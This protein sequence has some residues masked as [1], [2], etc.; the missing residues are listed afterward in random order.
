LKAKKKIIIVS[1]TAWSLVNFRAGLI[2][3][4]VDV[5]YEVVAIAPSDEYVPLLNNLGCRYHP[6]AMDN[7]G[8]KV[9]KDLLLLYRFFRILRHEQPVVFL[10]YTV[11]PNV[12]GSLA[13]HLLDIPVVNNISGLGSVFISND[14]LTHFVKGL[15]KLALYRSVKIFF[16]NEDDRQLFINNGLVRE[17]L[18]DRLPGSGV[19]IE[20]FKDQ[21]LRLSHQ[22][23]RGFQFLLIARML[24]DKGVG[25]YVA[26]ARIIKRSFPKVEFCLLGFLGVENPS[27]ISRIQMDE[28][29]SE[30]VVNYL[31]ISEDVREQIT[32][33]DCIVLPSYYRE[34]TPRTLLEAA[35]MSR[36]IITTDSV[37][38]RD[39]VDDGVNGYLCRPRDT[40][41][42]AK[43]MKEMISLSQEERQD[44]GM[45]GREKVKREFDE[46]IVIDR[47]LQFIEEIVCLKN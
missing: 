30:G 34:G 7:Q 33:A 40:N 26:A 24:W 32:D 31:G 9:G 19:N 4:L 10:G 45:R 18:T 44:M 29:V 46:K 5:G 43:K 2:L 41:D 35:A 28:W 8:T 25:E 6:L 11:K 39:V 38:C 47:Y 15:Y 42:L 1:N 23:K 13:A 14:W 21:D 3:A 12:Y 20:K 22:G 16:Q 37:G 17:E 36:P 27:A